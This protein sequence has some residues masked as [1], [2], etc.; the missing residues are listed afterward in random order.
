MKSKYIVVLVVVALA[1]TASFATT[2]T[3][4]VTRYDGNMLNAGYSGPGTVEGTFTSSTINFLAAG[5]QDSGQTLGD[6]L[7]HG[8]ANTSGMTGGL[9]EVMS[10]CFDGQHDPAPC[11]STGIVITGKVWFTAGQTYYVTH[12]D[13]V[14][15]AINGFGNVIDQPAPVPPETHS[16][17]FAGPSG[18]YDFTLSYMGTNGNPEVLKATFVPEPASLLLLG[19]GLLGLGLFR[20]RK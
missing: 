13:G 12:D 14:I 6:F 16:F 5:P 3:G 20:R 4:T 9:G 18:Y 19:S 8:G 7:A 11:Y 15:L 1:A 17:T 10:N 2:V